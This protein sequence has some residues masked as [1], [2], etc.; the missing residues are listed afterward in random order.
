M[1][2]RTLTRLGRSGRIGDETASSIEGILRRIPA[3]NEPDT[4]PLRETTPLVGCTL[5]SA[6][7]IRDT[8]ADAGIFRGT[9]PPS[10][11]PAHC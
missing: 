4:N 8:L 1:S 7:A 10:I 11:F 2:R 9:N 6:P 5:N 3:G